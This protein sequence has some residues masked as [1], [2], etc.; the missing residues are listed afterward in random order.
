MNVTVT[1]SLLR[2]AIVPPA[3]KSQGHRLIIAAALAAGTSVLTSLSDSQDIS[4]T[5]RCMEALGANYQWE[6]VQDEGRD[7]GDAAPSRALR[8]TGVPGKSAAAHESLDCGES[9]S[10]LRFLIPIALALAGGGTFRGRGRLMQRPQTPYF[11]IFREKGIAFSRQ[12]DT[13]II[14]GTLTP[15]QYRLRGDVSSQFITG[16]LFALPLLD[17]D[18]EITLTTALESSGYIHMTIDALSAFGVTAEPTGTGW[19]VPGNQRYRAADAAAEADYSQAA[20][21]Y[22]AKGMGN[23]LTIAG[24]DPSSH[25]GDRV[26]V[27]Y[28]AL[29]D[30]PGEVVLDVREC[31]DLVP[32]L[33]AR[34]ALRDGETTR[35][36]NAGRLRL[37]ES[38]RLASVTAVLNAMGADVRE[39]P[40][41]LTICGRADLRGGVTVDSWN[42]HR[43]AMMAAVAATRCRAPVTITGAECVR[44]SY[45]TFW[46]DLKALGGILE[47]TE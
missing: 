38:D 4:A 46:E 16:L 2:G 9:G 27:E 13:L 45:P 30:G 24:M 31:P 29:L 42:D 14:K 8:I 22:A 33:A 11:E 20:F 39:E 23:P 7:A 6:T 18:S 3:S 10:T 34:A 17:G 40:E 37:K 36:V 21:F 26:I 44:K 19:Y 15:G 43:I 5:L 1:P 32:A 25:Q 35:I 41:G 12:D 47:E 28:E